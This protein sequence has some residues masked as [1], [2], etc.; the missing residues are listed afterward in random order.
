MSWHCFCSSLLRKL[1]TLCLSSPRNRPCENSGFLATHGHGVVVT[2]TER[3]LSRRGCLKRLQQRGYSQDGDDPLEVVTEHAQGQLGFR[4]LQ[5]TDQKAGVAHQPLHCP[6]RV[7]S[8]FAA[9][10][11]PDRV[12]HSARVD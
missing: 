11:H 5:S 1:T 7:F 2:V 6:E 4:F 12:G 8:H 3:A 9:K 10:L